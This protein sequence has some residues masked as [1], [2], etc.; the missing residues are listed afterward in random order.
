VHRVTALALLLFSLTCTEFV[1]AEGEEHAHGD[2]HAHAESE[3][4]PEAGVLSTL[5]PL[6]PDI[7]V[8]LDILLAYF[9]DEDSL[10]DGA[11]DP[12]RTGF[13]LA[14]FELSF[15]KSVDTYFRLDSNILFSEHGV[16]LEEAYATTLSLPWGFRVRAGQLLTPF[17][18]IN[19]TH[20]H[21]WDFAERPFMWNKV[22]GGEGNRGLGAELSWLTPMPWYLEFVGSTT[23]A[24]GE[25][26][27]RSFYGADDQGID[28]PIDF[29]NTLA[30][31]QFFPLG[32]EAS[33]RWG[34]SVANGP[35]PSG[36]NTRTDIYGSDLFI[37]YRPANDHTRT[38][39]S[40][41]AEWLYRRRQVPA[42]V[43]QDHG[44][45][46][47][48]AWRFTQHWGVAARYE[49]GSATFDT[50]EE[51]VID[52]L[53]PEQTE[54]RHRGA[55]SLNFWPSDFSRLRL[56]QTIDYPTWR[57]APVWVAMLGLEVAFGAHSAHGY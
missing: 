51:M 4:K 1:H 3:N 2:E 22:F 13:N 57:S 44:G 55:T 52:P 49:Y 10:Q 9:S 48:I 40:L 39:L 17:G 8:T 14:Q 46:A 37:K 25:E 45:Y 23:H 19:G 28:S 15:S 50:R 27:A 20:L 54:P 18:R 6:L 24:A 36:R 38:S 47:Q 32:D 21:A 53:D 5:A 41:Q 7:G 30:I 35:N 29:Q 26:T 31:K 34:L 11:H 12:T 42:D 56:Q 43:L 33:L 16:E